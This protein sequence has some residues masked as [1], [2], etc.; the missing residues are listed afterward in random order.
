MEEFYEEGIVCNFFL[1]NLL[2]LIWCSLM[3]YDFG[4]EIEGGN[5]C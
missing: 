4:L 3:K 2:L 5:F 1:K